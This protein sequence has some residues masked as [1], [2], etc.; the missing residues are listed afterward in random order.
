MNADWLGGAEVDEEQLGVGQVLEHPERRGAYDDYT[1]RRFRAITA[2]LAAE[3][4]QPYRFYPDE[5]D[6]R[7]AR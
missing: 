5:T 2:P 1:E 7:W 4:G 3:H 6:R